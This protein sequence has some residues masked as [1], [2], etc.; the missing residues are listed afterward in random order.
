MRVRWFK[1]KYRLPEMKQTGDED[2]PRTSEPVLVCVKKEGMQV[3]VLE[4]LTFDDKEPMPRQWYTDNYEHR[5]LGKRVT[6]W[7]YLPEPPSVRNEVR[8][9]SQKL[10]VD[11]E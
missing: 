1:T 4:D 3:A 2:Y 7:A 5:S 8:D 11:D 6:H 10:G 9:S